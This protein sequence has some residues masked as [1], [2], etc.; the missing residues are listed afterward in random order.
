MEFSGKPVPVDWDA[1][2]SWLGLPLP[3]DY[4]AIASAHGPL[5]IGEF[6]W[7]HVPCVE[8]GRFDW[9]EWVKQTR[10]VADAPPH[11]VPWGATR[12]GGYLFWDSSV[13]ADPARW[14]VVGFGHDTGWHDYGTSLSG[15]LE[16]AVRTALPGLGLLP[17]SARRTAFLPDAR[18]WTPPPPVDSSPGR[19][20]ALAGGTGLATLRELVVPPAHPVLGERTWEWLYGELGTSLPA[21]YV[22]LMETYGSGTFAGW[23]RVWAPLDPHGLLDM[24]EG[25]LDGNRQLRA[26]FPEYHPLPLWPEPGGFLPFGDSIDGDQLGWLTRGEPDGWPLIFAPRHAGQGPPLDGPLADTLLEWL[27]GRLVVPGLCR[28]G[29]C[30]DPLGYAGF[31]PAEVTV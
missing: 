14:P 29:R 8:A 17:A 24:S 5:D 9:G 6:V 7:L 15:L 10:S 18:P 16:E 19:G 4:K 22:A 30:D 23:L 11:L 3:G 20:R 27:R 28:F 13:D 25:A 26:E 21:D 2:E 1:V 31:A 12:G